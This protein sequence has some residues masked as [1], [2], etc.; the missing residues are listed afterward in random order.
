VN[1]INNQ[2]EDR[3]FESSTTCDPDDI[4][5]KS[6]FLGP[7]AENAEWVEDMISKIFK[8]W[9]EWRKSLYVRDGNVITQDDQSEPSY[10]ERK[11]RFEQYLLQIIQR[12][13]HE[14]PNFTPR[15]IGH[16]NNEISLPGIM[17]HIVSLLHNPNNISGEASRVG[18]Q[19]ENEAIMDMAEMIGYNGRLS[20]GHFTSGGT[21]ANLEGSIR[22]RARMA[23]WL[24]LG[25]YMR[26]HGYDDMSLFE[27][28][29]M[30]WSRYD[31]WM[32]RLKIREDDL[33]PYHFIESN[34]ID[35]ALKYKHLFN[36]SYRGPVALIPG[37]KHYSWNKAVSFLGF[38]EEA[39]W[40]VALD[41]EG[42]LSINDLKQKIQ[43]AGDENRPILMVVSV[44][45]TTEMGIFDPIDKVSAYLEKLREQE[46]L[47]I[48]HHVDA[49]YGG[50]FCSLPKD[51]ETVI[52]DNIISALVSIK[53]ANS[54]TIDP[55]KL[56]YVPYSSGAFICKNKREYFSQKIDA[57][58]I[59]FDENKDK[60]TQTLE[61]SRS[62][63]GAVSTWLTSKSIGL[64]DKG[65]GRILELTI[66]SQIKLQ[67]LLTN[68]DAGIRINPVN[69]SNI[70]C[71]CV[72]KQGEA[73]SATN[74]RT[75]KIYE[76][77]SPVMNREFFVSQTRLGWEAYEAYLDHF[78]KT[79]NAQ[80]DSDHLTF[81]RCVMM[82][83]FF[84]TKE[85]NTDYAVE[86]VKSLLVKIDDLEH[87]HTITS[88][89][90]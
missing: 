14:V 15:Y 82:N 58:Y 11:Y 4:A 81:I 10:R 43:K 23:R 90:S 44:A 26:D 31:E 32:E 41:H 28:A 8:Q 63:S 1:A 55:H 45:G 38:G 56:G 36:S 24:S 30:G 57:P 74:E 77:F 65:Y 33:K 47:H 75:E 27:S 71:F 5:L 79:W 22:A 29:H 20:R 86:F 42:R 40:P 16:M 12:F 84:M 83:P 78:T 76:A 87:N 73:I 19:I 25:A 6:F 17:G 39:F 48:W 3:I 64:N 51:D 85:G 2:L 62:A 35:V 60:G 67:Q 72:A 66:K 80:K 49:A 89:K 53:Q 37:N 70:V 88:K 46:G 21:V 52:N 68:T 7:K 9:F 59:K 69:D 50:F 18:I 34:P 54:F 61:G 13:Q